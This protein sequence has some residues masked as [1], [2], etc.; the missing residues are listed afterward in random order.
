MFQVWM[1]SYIN[2][3]QGYRYLIYALD[4]VLKSIGCPVKLC[5]H[6]DLDN[7]EDRLDEINQHLAKGSHVYTQSQKL[8]QFEGY[9]YIYKKE[10]QHSNPNDIIIFLD[11]DDMLMP[12]VGNIILKQNIEASV[13]LQLLPLTKENIIVE[14]SDEINID[15]LKDLIVKNKDKFQVV[16]DFSG[17]YIKSK[18]LPGFFDD[19]KNFATY[20]I[21]YLANT[22]DIE[23]MDY[24]ESI[25]GSGKSNKIISYHRL[26]P[27]LSDWRITGGIF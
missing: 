23:F 10:Y 24:V 9:R 8:S 3:E 13:G 6:M 1:A 5:I 12:G 18:Y 27:Y 20:N 11:D 25:P 4:S 26:K 17:T 15:G 19:D 7:L 21:P 14:G 22:K 16:D 2:R